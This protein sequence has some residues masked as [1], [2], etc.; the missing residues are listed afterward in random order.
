MMRW[1]ENLL[2]WFPR[3]CL[4]RRELIFFGVIT[5]F[6]AH[7]RCRWLIRE[8]FSTYLKV[9]VDPMITTHFIVTWS[10][11]SQTAFAG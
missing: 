9:C 5:S 10:S 2:I 3:R 8:E 1:S 6:Q 7:C 11:F 4:I